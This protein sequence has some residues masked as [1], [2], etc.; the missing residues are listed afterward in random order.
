MTLSGSVPTYAEKWAAQKA[1]QRV[2]GVKAIAEELK[3]EPAAECKRKD[4][5][6]AESVVTSL[7]WHVWV[8][9]VVKATV[10]NGWV[11]LT[12]AVA[13]DYQ[14]NSAAD[15]VRYLSGVVGVSNDITI[16]PTAQ[17]TAVKDAIE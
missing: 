9:N 11:T 1:T 12:G 8:P 5:E 3:V 16:K 4:T 17:P 6:I 15:A 2:E 7:K 13:W 14:R 10:E